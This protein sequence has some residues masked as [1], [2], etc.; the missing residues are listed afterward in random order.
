VCGIAPGLPPDR[1]SAII[2]DMPDQNATGDS[3]P[4]WNPYFTDW[5]PL[6]GPIA[7]DRPMQGVLA[8]RTTARPMGVA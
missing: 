3:P 4:P 6:D 7:G 1:S 8:D 5:G 2:D